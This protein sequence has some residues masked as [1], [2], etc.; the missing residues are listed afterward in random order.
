MILLFH[1]EIRWLSKGNCLK[2]FIELFNILSEKLEMK[3]LLPV[4]DKAFVSHLAD[5]FEKLNI[6][7]KQVKLL[8]MQKQRYLV[9]T[10]ME[11]CQK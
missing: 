1:A 6:L 9:Y 7:K 2:R 3:H 11:L 5:I 10:F 8:P 4:D